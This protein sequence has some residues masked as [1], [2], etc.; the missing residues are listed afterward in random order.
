VQMIQVPPWDTDRFARAFRFLTYAAL[1]S[2]EQASFTPPATPVTVDLDTLFTYV[3]TYHFGASVSASD[4]QALNPDFVEI[5]TEAQLEVQMEAGRLVIE[6]TGS[7]PVLDFE[8]GKAIAV[9]PISVVEF[10]V[11]GGDHTRIAFIGDRSGKITGAILNPGPR[12]IKGLRI[13]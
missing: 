6:A 2:P 5:D 4:K 12:E 11:D 7:W 1:R 10:Y 9:R 8:I 3:G 13:D